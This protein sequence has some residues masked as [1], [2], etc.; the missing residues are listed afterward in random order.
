M[1]KKEFAVVV[2]VFLALVAIIATWYY[3][4]ESRLPLTSSQV[5]PA[6]PTVNSSSSQTLNPIAAPL[7]GTIINSKP[8]SWNGTTYD[9]VQSCAGTAQ[10]SNSYGTASWTY[11]VGDNILAITDAN[12]NLL[13]IIDQ[14]NAAV[15][16]RSPLML[17]AAVL[18]QPSSTSNGNVIVSYVADQC[19]IDT[20]CGA[21]ASYEGQVNF[22]VN[23]RDD[24]FRQLNNVPDVLTDK[25]Q[26]NTGNFHTASWNALG[27][28]VVTLDFGAGAGCWEFPIVA[29]DLTN[30]Q[31][32]STT[33]TGCNGLG[34]NRDEM[35]AS[36][37]ASG[38]PQSF[39]ANLHWIDDA[40]AEVTFVNASGTEK[41]VEI[42]FPLGAS[43]D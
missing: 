10:K 34:A 27:D 18:I 19:I 40:R 4:M 42:N 26:Y 28:K 8:V 17:N 14:R 29:Y 3:K 32:A 6:N 30:D 11:C 16:G 35:T 23:L 15:S 24:S 20:S 25:A 43:I 2:A 33:E 37:N 39:W 9:F 36:M 38:E 12:S 7:A 21:P 5:A 13:K 31:I 1:N 41:A 22:L